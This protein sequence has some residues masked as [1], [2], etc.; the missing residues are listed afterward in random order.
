MATTV[1]EPEQTDDRLAATAA[2]RGNSELALRAARDAFEQLYRRHAPLLLAFI[3]ARVG[4]ADREDLHQ[5]VWRRAWHH[6]PEQFHGGNF[7]AWLYQIARHVLID[8][9]KKKKPRLSPT[10]KSYPTVEAS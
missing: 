2:A 3:T 8:H 1:S 10:R 4:P 6:L 7:G 5:E 9:G